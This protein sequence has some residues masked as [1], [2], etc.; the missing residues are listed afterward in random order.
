MNA[1]SPFLQSRLIVFVQVPDEVRPEP[2]HTLSRGTVS[3]VVVL[4]FIAPR[5]DPKSLR[6]IPP[7]VLVQVGS[8]YD[9][10]HRLV[11]VA[12]QHNLA[13][14]GGKC[15]AHVDF[16]CSDVTADGADLN[17]FWGL[18]PVQDQKGFVAEGEGDDEGDNYYFSQTKY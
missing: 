14:V 9:Y 11:L 2:S 1:C 18:I 7:I 17:Q 16:N 3:L 12:Q 13:V 8:A 10:P 15:V 5:T 6:A 4:H